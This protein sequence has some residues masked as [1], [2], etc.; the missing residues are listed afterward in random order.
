[1]WVRTEDSISHK[2]GRH[3][4]II[5]AR[6]TAGSREVREWTQPLLEPHGLGTAAL[7]V[8]DIAGVL[9]V[10]LHARPEAGHPHGIELAPTVLC[11][12]DN[13]LGVPEGHRP[14]FLDLVASAPEEQVRFDAIQSEEGGRFH[15]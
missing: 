6:I 11:T 12:P 9:H 13:Y 4:S 5:G 7:L 8:K 15:Q 14:R 2:E 1:H 3:F 10:L